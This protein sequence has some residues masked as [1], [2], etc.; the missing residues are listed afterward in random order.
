MLL[1]PLVELEQYIF[2]TLT[3]YNGWW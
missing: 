2:W 3:I 1:I